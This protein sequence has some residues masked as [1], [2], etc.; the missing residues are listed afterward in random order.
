[1][2]RNKPGGGGNVNFSFKP[3]KGT[4]ILAQGSYGAGIG[5]YIGGLIPDVSFKANGT[6]SPIRTTSW[7]TGVEQAV[8]KTFS[9]AAYYN[10]VYASSASFRDID[11][12]HI[13]YGFPGSPNS[14]NRLIS[15]WSAVWG[16]QVF[17]T[18]SRGSVQ[19]NTQFSWLNRNPWARV[20]GMGYTSAFMFFT[21]MRYNLP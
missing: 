12:A 4:K 5:R 16:Y 8:G 9:L 15:E 1:M 21:Q 17:K 3:V 10:G 2:N 19:W 14:N 13:G 6:I 18:E 11:G 20:N 7:V